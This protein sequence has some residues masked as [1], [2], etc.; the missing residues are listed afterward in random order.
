MNTH[1]KLKQYDPRDITACMLL[2]ITALAAFTVA[3]IGAF[4]DDETMRWCA[5]MLPIIVGGGVFLAI[6]SYILPSPFDTDT[7]E[8]SEGWAA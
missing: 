6:L 4:S 7:D 3:C 8:D 5:Y 1:K 2:V